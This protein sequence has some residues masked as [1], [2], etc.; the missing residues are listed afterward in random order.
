ML[1]HQATLPMIDGVSP[2]RLYLPKIT[3]TPPSIFAYLCDTFSHISPADWQAR[4]RAGQVLLLSKDERIT[5]V[6]EDTAYQHGA[7]VYYYRALCDE[8]PVPFSHTVIYEDEQLMVVDKPHFLAVTPTG[9]Y[10]KESLL[11]RLKHA[12]GNAELSPIHRLDR[13]TAGLILFAKTAKARAAYQAL[14]ATNQIQ[15]IYHAIAPAPLPSTA[16]PM[17][18]SLRL[19]RGEPFYTMCVTG[20]ESNTQTHIDVLSLSGDGRLAK[21]LL[22]PKTGKLHQL[23]VHL[24]HLGTPIINDSFYPVVARPA[25]DDFSQPLQLLAK[26]LSFIDPLSGEHRVFHSP[27]D[28]Y[29]PD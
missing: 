2:S 21:Y 10:V 6:A 19:S 11:T 15:K 1:S 26:M 3:P 12:T 9:R 5:Q 16:L 13:E 23:R 8:V 18:L 25:D 27:Q 29:L 22:T 17:T 4:I 24:H 20:G 28:L 7:T 14:F